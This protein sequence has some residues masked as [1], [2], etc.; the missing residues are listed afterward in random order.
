[1]LQL[2]GAKAWG[3]NFNDVTGILLDLIDVSLILLRNL[4]VGGRGALLQIGSGKGAKRK[5]SPLWITWD[6]WHKKKGVT[7]VTP[8]FKVPTTSPF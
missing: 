8:I 5:R 4:I 2:S 1:V 6:L 7:E 3:G